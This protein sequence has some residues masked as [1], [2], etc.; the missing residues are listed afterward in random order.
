[1]SLS[2][3]TTNLILKPQ[4][5]KFL[6]LPTMTTRKYTSIKRC[7]RPQLQS[8]YTRQSKA[9]STTSSGSCMMNL[10][11][12]RTKLYGARPSTSKS[13]SAFTPSSL[14]NLSCIFRSWHSQHHCPIRLRRPSSHLQTTYVTT[15]RLP[16]N[17][18]PRRFHSL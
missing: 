7:L 8:W 2:R 5:Q 13:K 16:L 17:T 12:C 4:T 3:T 1:M 6:S 10:I 15:S 9:L 14:M 18:P 11:L